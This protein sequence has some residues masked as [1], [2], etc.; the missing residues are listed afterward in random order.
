MDA[1]VEDIVEMRDRLD[2]LTAKDEI[3]GVLTRY[4]RATDRGDVDLLKT[5]Y[6]EDG[7]DAHGEAFVGNAHEFAEFMLGADQ[8]GQLRDYR[9]YITNTTIELDEDRAFVESSFLCT[10]ELPLT[11]GGYADGQAEGRYFDVFLCREGEWKI[12][13]R[14]M[15]SEK[16]IWRLREAQPFASDGR[17]E[18][19]H[20][21]WPD[22][23][24]YQRYAVP[25]LIPPPFRVEGNPWEYLRHA[26]DDLAKDCR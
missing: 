23:P 2:A 14:L 12:W 19:I 10:L 4:A 3:R 8:L 16:Y 24:V 20:S 7:I 11:G 5:C 6:F 17:P 22:D 15:Q 13:R 9:H 1:E 26:L 21:K 18:G 25:K